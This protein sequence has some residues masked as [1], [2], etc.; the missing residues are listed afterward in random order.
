MMFGVIVRTP[1]EIVEMLM[2]VSLAGL[3]ITCRHGAWVFRGSTRV[4]VGRR[5][6]AYT[7]AGESSGCLQCLISCHNHAKYA[8]NLEPFGAIEPS[9]RG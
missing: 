2:K 9:K 5:V 8:T 3:G 7:L 6:I 4:C 1:S